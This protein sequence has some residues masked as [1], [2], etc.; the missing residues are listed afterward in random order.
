VWARRHGVEGAEEL[1]DI[2]TEI[3]LAE[4][5]ETPVA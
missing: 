3:L 5:E 1:A 4:R 2:A